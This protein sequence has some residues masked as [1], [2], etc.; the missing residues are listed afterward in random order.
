MLD[1]S[2]KNC[3]VS[4]SG[5]DANFCKVRSQLLTEFKYVND[6]LT[7]YG[8]LQGLWQ[9]TGTVTLSQQLAAYNDVKAQLNPPSNAPSQSLAS[10]LVNFFLGLASFD[11]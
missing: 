10:P 8:N 3:D 4:G 9:G 6:I 11:S 7:F 2:G 5:A 1:S